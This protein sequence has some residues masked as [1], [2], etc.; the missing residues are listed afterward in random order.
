MMENASA[1]LDQAIEPR[2]RLIIA[3][4]VPTAAEARGIVDELRDHV[5]AFKV[6]MQLFTAAGPEFVR[7]L[8]AA[9]HKVFLDLKFHDIPNTVASAANCGSCGT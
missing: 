5:G 7:E 4:D 3:L 9:G 1:A 6:G 2:Q 8:S